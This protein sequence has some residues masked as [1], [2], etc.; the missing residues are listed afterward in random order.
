MRIIAKQ[1]SNCKANIIESEPLQY[2]ICSLNQLLNLVKPDYVQILHFHLSCSLHLTEENEY[3]S[4][5][6]APNEI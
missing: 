5:W 3:N 6:L 1:I 4:V 2:L